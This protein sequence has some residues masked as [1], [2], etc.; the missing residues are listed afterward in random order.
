[1]QWRDD[2]TLQSC[3][4][5]LLQARRERPRRRTA[6]QRDEFAA[7]HSIS[8]SAPW[9]RHATTHS[10]DDFVGDRQERI[11]HGEADGFGGLEVDDQLKS[12]WN[13]DWQF[14]W[15]RALE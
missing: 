7:P 11:R 12:N 3:G 6:E 9:K 2:T 5:C 13:F 4:L 1:M 10:F 14:A 15:T 8:S